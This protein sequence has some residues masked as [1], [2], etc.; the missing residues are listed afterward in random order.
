MLSYDSWSIVDAVRNDG[1]LG[2]TKHAKMSGILSAIDFEKPFQSLDQTYFLEVLNAFNFWLSFTQWICTLH[3]N[4][5]SCFINDGFTF[6]SF[7]L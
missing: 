3:S 4:I 1:I 2:Y 6:Y 7:A 5:S